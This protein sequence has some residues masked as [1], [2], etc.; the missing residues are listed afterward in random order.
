LT[1]YH[2][3][4]RYKTDNNL[5]E[6]AIRPMAI[7]RKNYLFCGN[8]SAV[9][10]AALFYSLLGCCKAAEVNFRDRLIHVLN[11]IH[12]YDNDYSKDLAELLPLPSDSL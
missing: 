5:G 8:H 1:R 10:D 3:D 7:G 4:G 12:E 9:E 2:P 6:N 11:H